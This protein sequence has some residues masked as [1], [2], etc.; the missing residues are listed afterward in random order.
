MSTPAK[1][2]PV[3]DWINPPS[4]DTRP[5]PGYDEWLAA[6]IEAAIREADE[7]KL[8]PIEEVRRKFGLE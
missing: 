5:E 8:T 2:T 7:G 6:E 1:R 4:P 3:D